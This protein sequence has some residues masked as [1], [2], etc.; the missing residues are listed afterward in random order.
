MRGQPLDPRESTK[1]FRL[2]CAIYQLANKSDKCLNCHH[3]RSL[4][5]SY[6]S[7]SY[8]LNCSCRQFRDQSLYSNNKLQMYL[9]I[10]SQEVHTAYQ[11]S[12]KSVN[13]SQPVRVINVKTY[14]K[15]WLVAKYEYARSLFELQ[16]CKVQSQKRTGGTRDS[17]QLAQL[18]LWKV[19]RLNFNYRF[20]IF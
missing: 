10:E 18:W 20:L 14:K 17:M 13:A 3:A 7:N 8:C 15:L 6:G 1:R 11:I 19:Y 2:C 4:H 9:I 5:P 16:A 12:S